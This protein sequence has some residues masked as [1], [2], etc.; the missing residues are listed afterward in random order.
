MADINLLVVEQHAIDSLDGSLGSLSGLVVDE[1]VTLRTA[2]FIGGDLAG[3]DVA[4]SR[5]R[6]VQSLSI[7]K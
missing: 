3:E 1:T 6:V 2:M 7:V 4:E 5:E